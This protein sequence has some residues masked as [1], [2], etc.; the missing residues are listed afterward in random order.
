MRGC[1]H[2][3][4]RTGWLLVMACSC[5]TAISARAADLQVEVTLVWATSD[6]EHKSLAEKRQQLKPLDPKLAKEFQEPFK[7]KYYFQC[8]KQ[9]G[10]VPR[11]GSKVFKMSPKCEVKVTELAGPEVMVELLGEGKPV[12]RTK[13][14]LKPGELITIGHGDKAGSA[15]FIVVQRAEK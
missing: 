11:R 4:G 2:F 9:E 14:P 5:L 1:E 3:L 7:W 15:W 12:N 13:K 10:I 8:K 6:E